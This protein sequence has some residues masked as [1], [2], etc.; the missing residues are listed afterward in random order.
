MTTVTFD[1]SVGGNGLQVSD[2]A[3]EPN[4]LVLGGHRQFFVPALQQT[5][6][7]AGNVT[8]KAQQANT[9]ATQAATSANSATTSA[10]Q[11]VASKSAA[12][13][14]ASQAV[15]AKEQAVAAK[16]ALFNDLSN[17]N[18]PLK[19]AALVGFK[20]KAIAASVGR[21]VREKLSDYI[22]SKDFGAVGDGVADDTVALLTLKQEVESRRKSLVNMADGSHFVTAPIWTNNIKPTL[23]RMDKPA[24]LGLFDGT[25]SNPD[26]ISDD[27]VLWAQKHTRF[28]NGSD[29]FAHTVGGVFGEVVVHGTGE[30]GSADTDGTWIGSLG[31]AVLRTTN[32]GTPSTPD[33]DGYGNMIGVAGFAK[34]E[35]YPGEGNIA[36]GSWGYASGPEL[37]QV[38]FDALP[39][40]NWSLVGFE[41]NV[42]INH[43]DIG[44]RA[45]LSGKGS[46]VGFLSANY[47][48]QGTGVKDWTFGMVLDGSPSDGNY[49]GQD[50]T[51]WN[52]YYTGIL[53]DK[54]KSKGI[55]FGRYFANDSYGIHFPDS[56]AGDARPKSAIYVGN[57]TV[58]WGGFDGTMK[59][60]GDMWANSGSLFYRKAGEDRDVL[61]N[62]EY[63]QFLPGGFLGLGTK[64]PIFKVEVT[65]ESGN[66]FSGVTS[67]GGS[68]FVVGRSSSGTKSAPSA[69]QQDQGLLVVGARGHDGSSFQATN[70]GAFRF[71]AANLWTPSSKGSYFTL[72]V[73]S[74]GSTT[75]RERLRVTDTGTTQAGEDNTQNLG[76]A[77]IRWATVYAG[78]GSINTSDA[79]EKQEITSL[80][81]A[82]RRVAKKIKTLFKKF[83]FKDAV[84]KKGEEARIHF[85][86]VAQDVKRAFEE[87]GLVAERYA[88]LCYDEWESQPEVRDSEGNITQ[89]F[90]AAGSRYGIRYEELLAFVISAI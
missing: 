70:S 8:T 37:D 82:E 80:D 59:S 40:T 17:T 54:I 35:G 90:V 15:S 36:C 14:A 64:T 9:S 22:S 30:P 78:S 2:Q 75:I 52:G 55:R 61:L 77:A 79:N 45:V 25:S 60:D 65:E 69:S 57:N 87:E 51:K 63:A 88:L 43:P 5:V 28:D 1:P 86:V 48:K 39:A 74:Q 38:T 23:M 11:A 41:A 67:Y 32:Q 83:R 12:E 56:Y 66:V 50:V 26:T 20:L 71:N 34:L 89:E 84:I 18:D 6:A 58:N 7:V 33:F 31:N 73:T 81:E 72:S 44:E 13:V 3:G 29:R 62:G 4:T 24:V 16:D 10:A 42:D 47:R 76:S 19:G 49:T 21:T 46:S 27:P 85:G 68:A 53:V